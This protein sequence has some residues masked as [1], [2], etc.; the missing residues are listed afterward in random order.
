MSA[1]G[2]CG[3]RHFRQPREL[4]CGSP[5]IDVSAGPP[6]GFRTPSHK[7]EIDT[8]RLFRARPSSSARLE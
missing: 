8:T 4:R 5:L 3:I 2:R 1:D 7:V 6:Q